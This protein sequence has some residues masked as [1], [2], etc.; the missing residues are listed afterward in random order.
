MDNL[1]LI[2]IAVA[3]GSSVTEAVALID[4][5]TLSADPV[6]AALQV[7]AAAVEANYSVGIQ[8]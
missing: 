5:L 4:G 1:A 3:R 8:G 6:D 7:E 2:A